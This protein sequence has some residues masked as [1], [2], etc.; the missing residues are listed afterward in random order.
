LGIS[1]GLAHVE[2]SHVLGGRYTTLIEDE[3]VGIEEDLATDKGDK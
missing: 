3:E 2:A 1:A